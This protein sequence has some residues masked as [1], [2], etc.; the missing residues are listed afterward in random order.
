MSV[1]RGFDK[2]ET[3]V[4][5]LDNTLYPAR[6]ELWQQIDRRMKGYISD[7]LGIPPEEAFIIQKDYYRRYGT[8]LRGLMIE[9][10]IDA[11]AFL[12]HVHDVDLSGLAAEPRL[13]AAIHALPGRK[14]VYTNGSAAHARNVL[15]RLGLEAQFDGVHD[16]VAGSF[17][18]KPTAQAYRLFLEAHGVEAPR[19]AMFEDLARNLEVPHELGMT[20]I[21]VATP[22]DAHHARES[23]ELEGREARY[24]DHVTEDL[25]AFLEHLLPATA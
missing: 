9:H 8:S 3:W 17:H 22:E 10:G 20:T 5:D 12:H 18:P 24:V 7:L 23:W 2:V 4:F 16:I 15:A 19:A 13:S 1:S 11:D 25:A 21:L 14:L 6:H